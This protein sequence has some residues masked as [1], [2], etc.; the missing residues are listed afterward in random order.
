MF[1]TIMHLSINAALQRPVDA[2]PSAA[3]KPARTAAPVRSA[4]KTVG[5]PGQRSLKAPILADSL[6]IAAGFY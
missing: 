1:T 5:G 6:R 3:E 4:P 2:L